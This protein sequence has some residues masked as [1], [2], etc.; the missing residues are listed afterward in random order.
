MFAPSVPKC[1]PP[2][3][4]TITNLR[5]TGG[6]VKTG[7][8]HNRTPV[9]VDPL[10]RRSK[11]PSD[12]QNRSPPEKGG[13]ARPNTVDISKLHRDV[14]V[15]RLV[16]QNDEANLALLLPVLRGVKHVACWSFRRTRLSLTCNRSSFQAVL[17]RHDICR[18][19]VWFQTRNNA[20]HSRCIVGVRRTSACHTAL[21]ENRSR[22]CTIL[23]VR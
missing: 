22:W 8:A 13:N 15:N 10:H 18:M 19:A 20:T 12:V 14:V 4:P 1:T 7:G 5:Q 9:R 17:V 2:S 16:F 11:K 21:N 3:G 6:P 23:P